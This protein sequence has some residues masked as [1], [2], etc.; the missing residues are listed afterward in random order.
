MGKFTAAYAGE[1]KGHIEAFGT[2]F[3]EGKT[4]EV[5]D[6]F[7]AKLEG[8]PFF[9]MGSAPRKTG[10]KSTDDTGLK[11]EHHGGSKFN[12]TRGEEVVAE[13]LSKADADAFN[14]MSD[15]EKAEY[16]KSKN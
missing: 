7:R 6:K 1:A 11:A 8:N 9:K 16:V 12:I 13:G 15:E 4:A 10:G 2:T 5:D 3:P 14:A